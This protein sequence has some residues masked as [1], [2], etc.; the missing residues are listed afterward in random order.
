M[1]P[2]D[3]VKGL[4]ANVINYNLKSQKQTFKTTPIEEVTDPYF[5]KALSFF[6]SLNREQKQVFFLIMRQ[7][8]VDTISNVLGILDGTSYLNAKDED[9]ILTSSAGKVPL[10]G[11]LQDIFLELEEKSNS[12]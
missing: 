5:L 12:K 6:G 11:C 7:T 10:N 1:T 4:R 8:Q 3:F 2:L 9:F